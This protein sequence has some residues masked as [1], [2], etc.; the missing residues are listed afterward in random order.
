M[1]L[2][3]VILY[4][5]I[6]SIIFILLYLSFHVYLL[7]T[8]FITLLLYLLLYLLFHLT[9]GVPVCWLM[10]PMGKWKATPHDYDFEIFLT[11]SSFEKWISETQSLWRDPEAFWGGLIK[12]ALE[13]LLPTKPPPFRRESWDNGKVLNLKASLNVP[14][15]KLT[16]FIPFP[17]LYFSSFLEIAGKLRI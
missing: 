4:F 3:R 15:W 7:F 2:Q 1:N 5:A 10:G 17:H 6:Y 9:L 13:M 12:P 16:S 14:P 11:Q 8:I